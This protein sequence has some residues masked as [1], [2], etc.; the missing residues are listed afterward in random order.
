[1]IDN[2]RDSLS[3]E[4]VAVTLNDFV[5]ALRAGKQESESPDRRSR[6]ILGGKYEA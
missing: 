1:M 5:W 3:A 2:A 6:I 4:S